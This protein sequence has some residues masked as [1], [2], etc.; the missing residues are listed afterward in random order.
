MTA[1]S[2]ARD[3]EIV[4]L[5]HRVLH[6]SGLQRQGGRGGCALRG[7][8]LALERPVQK[9]AHVHCVV[10][11]SPGLPLQPLSPI[12]PQKAGFFIRPIFT[13]RMSATELGRCGQL[14]SHLLPWG[15][16]FLALTEV[17]VSVMKRGG[18]L[19]G[20][21]CALGWAPLGQPVTMGSK[22]PAPVAL[23]NLSG[24]TVCPPSARTEG[25]GP[26]WG[27]QTTGCGLSV[28]RGAHGSN[29]P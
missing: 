26:D 18:P 13:Y 19:V 2:L 10:R 7:N 15:N 17:S 28:H 9:K 25:A 12:H 6:F 5:Q 22:V 29:R 4:N 16:G 14:T 21:Q 27:H 11:P 1:C 3:H 24:G 8:S 20:G 23:L